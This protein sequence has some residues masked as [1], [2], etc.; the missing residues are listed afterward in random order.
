M[1][2]LLLAS[3]LALAP[4]LVNATPSTWKV[5][6]S[7]GTTSKVI[8]DGEYLVSSMK[9]VTVYKD[10]TYAYELGV[11]HVERPN[12]ERSPILFLTIFKKG[13]MAAQ[14]MTD[15]D[16]QKP[17]NANLTLNY[18]LPWFSCRPVQEVL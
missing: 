7:L 16:A 12:G 10:K 11:S 6:C 4:A 8:V 2:N 14:S 18:K 5:Q 17:A 15:F 13:K 9:N 1:K 3:F